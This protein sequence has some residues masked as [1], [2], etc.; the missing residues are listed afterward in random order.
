MNVAHIKFSSIPSPV[1]KTSEY[2]YPFLHLMPGLGLLH[3][4][5]PFL[6]P[7]L[8]CGA[9]GRSSACTQSFSTHWSTCLCT[10]YTAKCYRQQREETASEIFQDLGGT[11][12]VCL[13]MFVGWRNRFLPKRNLCSGGRVSWST[14][15]AIAEYRRTSCPVFLSPIWARHFSAEGQPFL[16]PGCRMCRHLGNNQ[17][18]RGE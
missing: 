4:V 6:E 10:S 13:V 5:V 2:V 17:L 1:T 18:G 11:R 16:L 8:S 3:A 7:A 15:A 14:W 12:G 9:S